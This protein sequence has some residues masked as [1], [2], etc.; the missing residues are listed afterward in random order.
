MD[1][2][3]FLRL[4]RDSQERPP[5]YLCHSCGGEI[6]PGDEYYD[7]GGEK[8]CRECIDFF[9]YYAEE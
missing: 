8:L 5:R 2:L 7:I 6:Y 1:E 4:R 3:E 9:R